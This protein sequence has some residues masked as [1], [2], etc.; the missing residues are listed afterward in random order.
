MLLS[1]SDLDVIDS[2]FFFYPTDEIFLR[3]PDGGSALFTVD[4]LANG[5]GPK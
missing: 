4:F 2:L 3:I 5:C 1:S